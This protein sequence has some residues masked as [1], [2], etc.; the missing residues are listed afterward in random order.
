MIAD[1]R[2][3]WRRGHR[4]LGHERHGQAAARAGQGAVRPR[5]V[6]S[7][8][9][10]AGSRRGRA[11]ARLAVPLDRH[12]PLALCQVPAIPDVRGRLAS[13][14]A[15][16]EREADAA[17]RIMRAGSSYLFVESCPHLLR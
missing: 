10:E 5:V 8:T 15:V 16:V 3:V 4:P 17:A 2:H 13:V 9:S 1:G 6:P 14:L 12:R 11:P 7:G